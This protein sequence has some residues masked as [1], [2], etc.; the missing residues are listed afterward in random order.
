LFGVVASAAL[1]AS[2]PHIGPASWGLI[3]HWKTQP[4]ILWYVII[5]LFRVKLKGA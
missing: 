2:S 5:G 1:P 4:G 3:A